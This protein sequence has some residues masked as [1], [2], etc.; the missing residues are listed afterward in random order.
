M[1]QPSLASADAPS[2]SPDRRGVLAGVAAGVIALACC[3]GPAATALVGIT[4]AAVAIDVA[5]DLYGTWGWAFKLAGLAF[6]TAAVVISV[7]QRRACGTEPRVWRLLGVVA[8][9]GIV[10]Y[11]LLYVGTTWLGMRA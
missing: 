5:T 7:R 2:P 3:V 11:S 1:P 4:S 9:A 8:I 10:T 6:A